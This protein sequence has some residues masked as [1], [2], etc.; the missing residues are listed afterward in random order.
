[1]GGIYGTMLPIFAEQCSTYSYFNMQ[2]SIDSG[3]NTISGLSPVYG[4][5]RLYS[6]PPTAEGEKLR[7]AEG[8]LAT[9][10]A[11]FF[12]TERKLTAGWFVS[13]PMIPSGTLIVTSA[14]D[15][16]RLMAD[17]QFDNALGMYVYGLNKLVGDN[18]LTVSSLSYDFGTG[19]FA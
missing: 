3:Y 16:Y 6:A 4:I 7:E 13:N 11:P 1:M 15:V 14:T 12:W 9:Q 19:S 17:N 5:L 2:P 10:K 8:N 18:G